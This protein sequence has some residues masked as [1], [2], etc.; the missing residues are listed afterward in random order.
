MKYTLTICKPSGETIY[1]NA[2][3]NKKQSNNLIGLNT[4]KLNKINMN[5]ERENK[6][7][8]ELSSLVA[9]GEKTYKEAL[10]L[11]GSFALIILA[12]IITIL[13]K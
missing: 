7:R 9:G 3:L 1:R 13:I 4:L 8:L 2:N 10:L 6:R 11:V 12:T 5:K